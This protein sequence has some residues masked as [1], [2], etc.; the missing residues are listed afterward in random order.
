MGPKAI[1]RASKWADGIYGA[2]MGGD[3]EGHDVIFNNARESWKESGRK[4]KPYLI[5]SFWYSLSPNAKEDLQTYTYDY[6]KYIDDGFAR[7]FA[8]SM[9]RHTPD[10]IREGIENLRAAGA[11]E[12]LLVPATAHYNEIDGIADLL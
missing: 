8:E 4:D 10:A 11:D 3:R 7:N 5:G 2:S 9:T 6:M 1:A 12:V